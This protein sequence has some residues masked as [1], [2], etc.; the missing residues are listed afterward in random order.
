VSSFDELAH[1]VE[2]TDEGD[3][4][5]KEL[6]SKTCDKIEGLDHGLP[7]EASRSQGLEPNWREKLQTVGCKHT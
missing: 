3:W 1:I 7:T 2:D 5:V 6:A 4:C